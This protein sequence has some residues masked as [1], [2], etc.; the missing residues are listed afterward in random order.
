ME[1]SVLASI[2]G[3]TVVDELQREVAEL[4]DA[5]HRDRSLAGEPTLIHPLPI[6]RE[7]PSEGI[8]HSLAVRSLEPA[9]REQALLSLQ[10]AHDR[11]QPL[12]DFARDHEL[13]RRSRLE[14]AGEKGQV[15]AQM[16]Q[17]HHRDAAPAERVVR[18]V[19]L[20]P[21][22]VHPDAGIE[23]E[24]REFRQGRH[25][26][27][28]EQIRVVDRSVHAAQEFSVGARALHPQLDAAFTRVIEIDGRTGVLQDL[29]VAS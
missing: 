4:H 5:R 22:R 6:D 7:R 15:T 8:H 1:Q 21:L 24:I 25:Q 10:N 16:A 28:L 12:Y 20:G 2:G 17:G 14:P 18:V 11:V 27:L 29:F 13:L 23:D 19:P 26:Q 9:A 3:K